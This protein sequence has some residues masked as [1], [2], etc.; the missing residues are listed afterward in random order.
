MYNPPR[1]SIVIPVYNAAK[2]LERCIKSVIDQS[3]SDFELLLVDDGS[4]D[5]SYDICSKYAAVDDR[6]FAIR[7]EKNE[8]VSIVRN[9]GI[10]KSSGFFILFVDSDDYI[11]PSYLEA[12]NEAYESNP[13]VQL[14]T[15]NIL[16]DNQIK[17][18]V[19]KD[20]ESLGGPWGKTF[21]RSIVISSN[22]RFIPKL[23]YHEDS[24]FVSDYLEHIDRRVQIDVAM[25]HYIQYEECSSKHVEFDYEETSKGLIILLKRLQNNQFRTQFNKEFAENRACFMFRRYVKALY[26]N[27]DCTIQERRNN[28]KSVCGSCEISLKYYPLQYR[29]DGLIRWILSCRCY[30]VAVIVSRVLIRCRQRI[31]H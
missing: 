27:K 28:L 23:R 6:I 31:K 26:E 15:Q 19:I 5:Q 18:H 4:K 8:G 13:D 11:D 20:F 10:E 9:L 1:F 29:S 17:C 3:F 7:N 25:Y 30:Y 14:I 2:Y 16:F 24:I 12:F 21:L 22:I